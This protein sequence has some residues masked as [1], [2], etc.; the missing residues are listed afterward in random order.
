[1]SKESAK[2]WRSEWLE[3]GLM[4]RD[5]HEEVHPGEQI[6]KTFIEALEDLKKRVEEDKL[7]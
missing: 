5:M 7:N 6:D 4:L 1:M 3:L 2:I